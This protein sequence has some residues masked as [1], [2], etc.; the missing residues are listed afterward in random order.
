M[1]L[2]ILML[3]MGSV[4]AVGYALAGWGVVFLGGEINYTYVIGG[5]VGGTISAIL[6]L[7]LW[8]RW[9]LNEYALYESEASRDNSAKDMD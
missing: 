2:I 5:L 8:Q 3:S 6:S 1:R 7:W 9:L 4:A